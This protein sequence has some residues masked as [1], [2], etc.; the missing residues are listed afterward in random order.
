VDV[1]TTSSRAFLTRIER[2]RGLD[3]ASFD[4]EL[5]ASKPLW[6]ALAEIS[7]AP[8]TDAQD[9]CTAPTSGTDGPGRSPQVQH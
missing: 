1:T 3:R 2:L 4:A 5:M 6:L 8:P 7:D 9:P